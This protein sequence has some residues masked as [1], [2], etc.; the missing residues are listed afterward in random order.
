[1]TTTTGTTTIP[2][3]RSGRASADAVRTTTRT[4]RTL[5]ALTALLVGALLV[6]G[7]VLV[8]R[9]VPTPSGAGSTTYDPAQVRWGGADV[10][11]RAAD[12][13]LQ[14]WGGPDVHDHA[15]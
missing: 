10:Q 9:G 7:A 15:R 4:R 6:L 12:P 8:L 5:A 3:Q 2:A 13:A 11:E 14:R 1:M